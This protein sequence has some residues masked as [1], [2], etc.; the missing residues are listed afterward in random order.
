MCLHA[1]YYVLGVVWLDEVSGL[2]GIVRRGIGKFRRL[3]KG[4]GVVFKKGGFQDVMVNHHG[5]N[6]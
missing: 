2:V 1:F 6:R 5:V 3:I 4:D